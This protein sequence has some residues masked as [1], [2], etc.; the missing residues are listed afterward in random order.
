VDRTFP[1]SSKLIL[2]EWLTFSTFLFRK[3]NYERYI[4]DN[5]LAKSIG[6][7]GAIELKFAY[8]FTLK[9]YSVFSPFISSSISPFYYHPNN[10]TISNQ[11]KGMIYSEKKHLTSFQIGISYH[12][13]RK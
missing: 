9:N 7:G 10:E 8:K 12:F 2:H 13:L 4:F 11:T 5:K 6:I 1:V 3:I